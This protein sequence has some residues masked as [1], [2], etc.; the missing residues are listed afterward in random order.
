MLVVRTNRCDKLAASQPTL[1]L[2]LLANAL[3][4]TSVR[5]SA[6][7]VSCDEVELVVLLV[8]LLGEDLPGGK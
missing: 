4:V 2:V 8:R 1:F 7:Q 3:A 5:V 6:G